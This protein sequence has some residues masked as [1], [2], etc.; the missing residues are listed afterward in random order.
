[1]TLTPVV[2]IGN[3]NV[4]GAFRASITVQRSV[5]EAGFVLTIRIALAYPVEY[6]LD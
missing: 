2:I 4:V 1:M 3:N 5:E 6:S